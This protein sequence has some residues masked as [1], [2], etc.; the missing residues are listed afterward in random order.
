M[1]FFLEKIRNKLGNN[2][3]HEMQMMGVS[4]VVSSLLSMFS[5]K[6]FGSITRDFRKYFES[7]KYYDIFVIIS[8]IQTI[9]NFGNHSE[10]SESLGNFRNHSEISEFFYTWRAIS[11]IPWAANGRTSPAVTSSSIKGARGYI[12]PFACFPCHHRWKL[13]WV[14]QRSFLQWLLDSVF[15]FA[16]ASEDY[17]QHG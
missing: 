13:E 15:L 12:S 7:R 2:L 17:N 16:K 1:N 11:I 9:P 10:L 5:V 14:F 4:T 3:L 8:Q 6:C